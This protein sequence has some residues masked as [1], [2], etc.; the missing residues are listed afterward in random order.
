[1]FWD[2]PFEL[3]FAYVDDIETSLLTFGLRSA[4]AGR[5]GFDE[6]PDK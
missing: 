6:V 1:M 5:F 2:V 3:K 4:I